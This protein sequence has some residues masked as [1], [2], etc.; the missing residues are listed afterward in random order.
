MLLESLFFHNAH[1]E[2][3]RNTQKTI[4]RMEGSLR[5]DQALPQ[6]YRVTST[7][8]VAQSTSYVLCCCIL[9]RSAD[10]QNPKAR[11]TGSL[12]RRKG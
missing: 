8:V 6:P 5:A 1:G 9:E 3:K 11:S 12:V 2:S 10:R 7:V 4:E